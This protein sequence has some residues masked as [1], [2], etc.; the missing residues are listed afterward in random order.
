MEHSGKQPNYFDWK[1]MYDSHPQSSLLKVHIERATHDIFFAS[2]V[3]Q[4]IELFYLFET[5]EQIDSF[6][7]RMLLYWEREEEYEKC[8]DVV[9]F[10]ASL[11]ELWESS[12]SLADTDP[13]Q[14]FVDWL[15]TSL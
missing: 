1:K 15:N 11:M 6:L 7:N 9:S 4:S 10:G 2:L 8:S 12:K 14:R 13:T 3:N 5:K